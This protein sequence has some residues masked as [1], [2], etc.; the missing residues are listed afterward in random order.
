MLGNKNPIVSA[1]FSSISIDMN[2]QVP[3]NVHWK[4]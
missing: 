2:F 1:Y 4:F 3:H